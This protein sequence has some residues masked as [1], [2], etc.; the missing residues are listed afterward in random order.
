MFSEYCEQ[1]FE[2]EPVEVV[3]AFGNTHGECGFAA[4]EMEVVPGKSPAKVQTKFSSCA[5]W[6]PTVAGMPACDACL[7]AVD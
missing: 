5:V 7:R 4:I 3:D 1:P 2:V 6:R